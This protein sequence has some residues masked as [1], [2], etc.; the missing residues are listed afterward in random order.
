MK[1]WVKEVTSE[2]VQA[3]QMDQR[4]WFNKR[5]IEVKD[6]FNVKDIIG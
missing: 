5:I 6:I 4:A 3:A 2:V 1:A